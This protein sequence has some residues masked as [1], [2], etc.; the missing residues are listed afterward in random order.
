MPFA[1]PASARPE[2]NVRGLLRFLIASFALAALYW[3]M[4]EAWTLGALQLMYAGWTWDDPAR[5]HAAEAE[6]IAAEST[7]HEAA[8]GAG[9]PQTV[10]RLG[11][12]YGNV[13][14]RRAEARSR[15]AA[16]A[17]ALDRDVSF[18]DEQA[19]FLGIAPV[20]PPPLSADYRFAQR[21]E[22]DVGGVAARIES[23]TSPRLRHLFML[24]ALAGGELALLDA[25][26]EPVPAPIDLIARHAVVSGIPA[27]LWHAI[28]RV[29]RNRATAARNYRA[30]VDAIDGY[31]SPRDRR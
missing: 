1:L 14:V 29:S 31:L 11:V 13:G 15:K 6:R 10:F 25:E 23:A 2:R 19:R 28:T 9:H 18:I 16:P 8:L 24:G 26:D 7:G 17:D 22:D 4:G 21:L 12:Q 5:T 30:A 20:D 27:P 3:G